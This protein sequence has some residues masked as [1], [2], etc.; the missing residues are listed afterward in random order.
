M[1][2]NF[3]Q[4]IKL[5]IGR[6]IKLTP[7][8]RLAFHKVLGIYKS[9]D[10]INILKKEMQKGPVIRSSAITVLSAFPQN[11]AVE[12]LKKHLMDQDVSNEEKM[13][14]LESI[15]NHG[16]SADLPLLMNFIDSLDHVNPPIEIS[17]K[18]FRTFRSLG[19]EDDSVF[20]Y[21]VS[22]I[23]N[24]EYHESIRAQAILTL[25]S[26]GNIGKFEE[27]LKLGDDFLSY[28][29]YRAIT[30]LNRRIADKKREERNKNDLFTYPDAP[31]EIDGPELA[32]R[33]LLGSMSPRFDGF[34]NM[35]KIAFIGAMV[36]C[37]HREYN[38]YVSRALASDDHELL[39]GTLHV[40][41][42]NIEYLEDADKL[43]RNLIF[44]P[45][46][47]T[48]E[49]DLI[50]SIFVKFFAKAVDDRKYS[51]L[52]ERVYSY[53]TISMQND[54]EAYS[55]EYMFKN[56]VEKNYTEGFQLFR[57]FVF[58]HMNP[59]LRQEI[60]DFLS[61]GDTENTP[62]LI[63]KL[64]KYIQFIPQ[65]EEQMLRSF[66]DILFEHDPKSR[67][68]S[69]AGIEDIN[70]EKRHLRN[71]IIRLCSIIGALQIDGAASNIVNS[72]NYMKKYPDP[73]LSAVM[74]STLAKLQYSYLLGEI[75]VLLFTG[76]KEEHEKGLRLIAHF[77][78]QRSMNILLEYLTQN[79]ADDSPLVLMA[80]K[81]LLGYDL[82][83]NIAANNIF[84]KII[85]SNKNEN[86]CNL[87]IIGM[88]HCGVEGEIPFLDSLFYTRESKSSKVAAIRAM[89]R[90]A[91]YVEETQTNRFKK[92][93]VEYL[94]DQS[95]NVRIYANFCLFMLGDSNSFR[96]IC[97]MLVI[98]NKS[99]Q[100]EIISIISKLSSL[101]FAFF[102][103]SLLTEEYGISNDIIETLKLLPTEDIREIDTFIINI[104]RKYDERTLDDVDVPAVEKIEVKNLNAE[105]LILLNCDI[106]SND[107]KRSRDNVLSDAIDLSLISIAFV[108]EA[109]V[110][111]NGYI[112][113]FTND[114][115]IARFPDSLSAVLASIDI[116]NK[117][118]ESN[119]LRR[120][121][122]QIIF[123]NQIVITET[124]SF[125][126]ETLFYPL[127]LIDSLD[128]TILQGK[129]VLDEKSNE[130]ISNNFVTGIIPDLILP[131]RF[132]RDRRFNIRTPLNFKKIALNYFT[133][134]QNDAKKKKEAE[135]ALKA[136]IKNMYMSAN[137][138]QIT[139]AGKLE[140]ISFRLLEN[141]NVIDNYLSTNSVDQKLNENVHTMLTKA[142]DMFKME[143]SKLIIK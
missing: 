69:A 42:R 50:I 43:F 76:T 125:P 40:L 80:M 101:D 62:V 68:N 118:N 81:I 49:N 100:R 57:K 138:S 18:A 96:A 4:T 117:I 39:T 25:S 64:S 2:D 36:S 35:T 60:I 73:Q 98:K 135:E 79:Y 111:H 130:A 90:L 119:Q 128:Q 20:N 113:L 38:T 139:M 129:T 11:E 72:Y 78:E 141:F 7:Y 10:A 77:N 19:A 45:I 131:P 33:V 143:I 30:I 5:E 56:V 124:L 32:I 136:E 126:E 86:I 74:E 93:L 103:I 123:T 114:R 22:K 115:V 44:V 53:I 3:L 107:P 102:L 132:A 127:S 9:K 134:L 88:G 66:M 70:Y 67:N 52:R 112:I 48:D 26:F 15:L 12:E 137:P 59:E 85:E 122:D 83:N 75:E 120:D 108:S 51:I 94:K 140:N 61:Q 92:Y 6:N 89:G 65:E 71:R 97:E 23:E 121:D 34:S 13:M 27:I 84:K 17:E 41:L 1:A 21:L 110:H 106:F 31:T 16:G 8:E 91:P 63:E 104:F 54:F 99:I 87:A 28:Y 105:E 142:Y 37:N 116:S 55:K 95:I 47:S 133:K 29:T 82:I 46:E 109:I 24:E 14:I 58:E